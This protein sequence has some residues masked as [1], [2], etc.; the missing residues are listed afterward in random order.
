MMDEIYHELLDVAD[1]IHPQ[2]KLALVVAEGTGRR[3]SASP[4]LRW[5]DVDFD[6]KPLGSIRWRAENDK[7]G[8][9]QVVPSSAAVRDTLLEA[10]QQQKAI[11]TRCVFPPDPE[12]ADEAGIVRPAAPPGV[13]AGGDQEGVGESLARTPAEGRHRAEGVFD[14]RSG[15][16]GRLEGYVDPVGLIPPDGS[17]DH[18][19][20]RAEPDDAAGEQ[21]L[22]SFQRDSQQSTQQGD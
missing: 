1:Q 22:K 3:L 17:G 19:D 16:G 13:Q 12:A 18:Q 6:A 8:Y 4:R 7:N 2:L 11:E 10:R 5:D 21:I 20:G 15:G 14:Q 9:E